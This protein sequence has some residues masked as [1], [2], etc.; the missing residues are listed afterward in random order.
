MNK[1]TL[2]IIFVIDKSGSMSGLEEETING[3]N[4]FLSKE[5]ESGDNTFVTTLLFN[6]ENKFIHR[7][8]Q[9]TEVN[10]MTKEDYYPSGTTSLYDA[11][12]M[13]INYIE[14][15]NQIKEKAD[16]KVIFV[17]ITD[18]MENSSINYSHNLINKM[19]KEKRDK[20]KWEFIFLGTNFD[21][22]EFAT[23]INIDIENTIKFEYSKDGIKSNY[24]AMS[25]LLDEVRNESNNKSWKD[26]IKKEEN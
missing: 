2:E 21:V 15:E 25:Y 11:V 12:G 16:S 4:E 20:S 5:K 18:G 13:A 8:E 24:E 7:R 9:I 26:I 19:I 23:S 14:L 1:K 10:L 3:Y 17:I 22:E 6:H